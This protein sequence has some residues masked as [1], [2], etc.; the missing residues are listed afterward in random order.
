MRFGQIHIERQ[1][2]HV[3]II[4]GYEQG[5]TF[6]NEDPYILRA[7]IVQEPDDSGACEIKGFLLAVTDVTRADGWDISIRCIAGAA[8]LG[9]NKVYSTRRL[10]REANKIGKRWLILITNCKDKSNGLRV[11]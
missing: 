10:T 3:H 8:F 11:Y 4:R 6:E 5:R 9:F 7:D 2:E 1:C